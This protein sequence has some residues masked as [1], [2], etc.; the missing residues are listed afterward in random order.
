M[1][2]DGDT[3]LAHDGRSSRAP[4]IV[5]TNE[6]A[7]SADVPTCPGRRMVRTEENRL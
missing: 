1:C 5:T 2:R 7:S 3:P 4:N 6:Q